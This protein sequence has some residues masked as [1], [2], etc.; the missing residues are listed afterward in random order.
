M[1]EDRSPGGYPD[2]QRLDL[3]EDLN[4]VEVSDPYRWLEDA[5]S[6]ATQDWLREQD[7]LFRT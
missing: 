5:G 4:G 7:G 6:P 1:G 2:A 3:V